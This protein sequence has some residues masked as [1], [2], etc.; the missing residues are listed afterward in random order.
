VALKFGAGLADAA[1]LDLARIEY[2]PPAQR[3]RIA[4]L[5][6]GALAAMG[7]NPTAEEVEDAA[8]LSSL[9]VSFLAVRLKH[10]SFSEEEEWRLCGQVGSNAGQILDGTA[11]KYRRTGDRLIPYEECE[12]TNAMLLEEVVVG[13]SSS[14]SLDAARLFLASHGFPTTVSRSSVPVR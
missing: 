1:K 14:F 7:P 10:P 12:F 11:L 2:D 3:A 6:D 8:H 4:A 13:Y 9:W 5:L